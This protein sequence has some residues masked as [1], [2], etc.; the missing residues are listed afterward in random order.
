MYLASGLFNCRSNLSA[1]PWPPAHPLKKRRDS[2]SR[3]M[4][5]LLE[6]AE[7]RFEV[8][9]Q[10]AQ[11]DA[12]AEQR[13][14]EAKANIMELE[15][16]AFTAKALSDAQ[17]AVDR[18]KRQEAEALE[19]AQLAEQRAEKQR[20]K[21][22]AE[23]Q[24]F[25][26]LLAEERR[27]KEVQI[28]EMEALMQLLQ[29][30]A[31]REVRRVQ[32]QMSELEVRA[33][34][35]IA[36]CQRFTSKLQIQSERLVKRAQTLSDEKTQALQIQQADQ[37][38]ELQHFLE[39]CQLEARQ[40]VDRAQLDAEIRID[41]AVRNGLQQAQRGQQAADA[42]LA[43]TRADVAGTRPICSEGDGN[44]KKVMNRISDF[45]AQVS[46]QLQV[47]NGLATDAM[48][49][50]CMLSPSSHTRIYEQ[51]ADLA[52]H[53]DTPAAKFCACCTAAD[54]TP[55]ESVS[56]PAPIPIKDE[57]EP[58]M[59]MPIPEAA[60]EPAMEEKEPD[61]T[62]TFQ[63]LLPDGSTKDIVV[64]SKPLGLDFYKSIPLTV[65]RVKP[66]ACA[67]VADVQP[68]WVLKKCDGDEMKEDLKDAMAQL[69][70]AV[71][72]LKQR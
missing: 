55:I 9:L 24:R 40:R 36:E 67:E 5:L 21:A 47:G 61:A 52:A 43:L 7:K 59:R 23:R 33:A 46:S 1:E 10:L 19:A 66:D 39:Q 53:P 70:K 11:K 35:R 42:H 62:V 27:E 34:T 28:F 57:T 51:I 3:P 8:R 58:V 20:L 63:F 50:I 65:K 72:Y 69:V 45:E 56:A 64:K 13:T 68:Q 38:R 49:M 41:V 31:D 25:E 44:I 12:E 4:S 2:P 37:L 32:E 22:E 60:P 16:R 14:L 30:D 29:S 71:Q 54:T 15:L 6:E 18:A 26:E 17:L 48:A